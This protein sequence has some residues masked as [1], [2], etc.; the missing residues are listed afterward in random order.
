MADKQAMWAAQCEIE[1]NTE[2]KENMTAC[3]ESERMIMKVV[4]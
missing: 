4:Q 1:N 2:G 3:T